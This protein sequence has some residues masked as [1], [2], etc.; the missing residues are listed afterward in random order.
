MSIFSQNLDFE[1][2]LVDLRYYDRTMNY[3]EL[4]SERSNV[5]F[6]RLPDHLIV[7]YEQ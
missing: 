5:S 2:D 7:R 6:N 4:L 1:P 3:F